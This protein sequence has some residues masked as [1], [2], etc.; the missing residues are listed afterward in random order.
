MLRQVPCPAASAAGGTEE[1]DQFFAF[2]QFLLFKAENGTYLF[3]PE[4]QTVVYAQHQRTFP[5]GR[6]KVQAFA[7]GREEFRMLP[8]E[9]DRQADP[10]E[11]AVVGPLFHSVICHCLQDLLRDYV[12]LHQIVYPDRAVIDGDSE[13][14]NVK[15]V[16]FSITVYAAFHDIDAGSGLQVDT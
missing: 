5:C 2:L 16:G 13:K 14:Q 8:A 9:P 1:A 6:I 7:V 4:G 12:S 10:L 15:I 11:T 3:H